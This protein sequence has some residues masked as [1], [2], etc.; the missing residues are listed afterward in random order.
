MEEEVVEQPATV[1]RPVMPCRP[2]RRV[3]IELENRLCALFARKDV[4][5]A[6]IRE[7]KDDPHLFDT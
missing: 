4:S 7:I 6:H 1:P 5:C 3:C 2:N